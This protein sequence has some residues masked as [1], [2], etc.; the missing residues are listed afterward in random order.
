MPELRRLVL[1]RHGETDGESSVRY[2]GSTD[3]PLSEE[4]RAQLRD[5]ARS[6]ARE[7]FDLVVASPLRR[8]WEGARIVSGGAPVRLERDFREIHFGRWEGLSA[9]EIA[10]RDPVLAAEWK[11]Q[12]AGFEYPG[13]ELRADFRKRVWRGLERLAQSGAANVLLVGHKG[14]IRTIAEKL[15]GEA[16]PPGEP[17]VAGIVSLSRLPDGSWILGRRSSNPAGLALAS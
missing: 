5:A 1:I 14:V 4:G 17:P 15:L 12:A 11:A 8:S 6:L 7:A 13:G 9:Q 10:E 3:L 16:L 2:H